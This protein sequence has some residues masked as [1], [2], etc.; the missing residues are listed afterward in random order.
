MKSSHFVSWK[1]WGTTD[2]S[3][4]S[5]TDIRESKTST[6]TRADFDHIDQNCLILMA[7]WMIVIRIQICGWAF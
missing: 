3:N 7:C 1:C 6:V 4:F 2:S 5:V